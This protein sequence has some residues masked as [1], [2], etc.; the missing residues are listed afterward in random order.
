[1]RRQTLETCLNRPFDLILDCT[2]LGPENMTPHQWLL[3]F[4]SMIP[5][6][7]TA[8]IRDIIVFNINTT[9]KLYARPWFPPNWNGPQNA[10]QEA[11]NS[12]QSQLSIAYCNSIPELEVYIERRNIALSPSSVAIATAPIEIRFNQ[13]TMVWYYRTLIPVSF[14]IG[15]DHLQITALKPQE[16]LPSRMACTNEVFHLAEIDDVRAIS[17]RGD[18]NTFFVTCRGGSVSFLFNSRDRTEIVQALRQAKARV[19]RFRTT[20][21]V[22]RTLLPSDVPGTLLNMAMIN[23]TS[24]D[25]G[26][27]LCAYDLLCALSTS[28]N[29]GASN[30]RK[31]L[32]SAKGKY[33]QKTLVETISLDT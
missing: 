5:P 32:L 22:D 33:S 17:I 28:F 6:E 2:A 25:Y 21:A 23:I 14:R 8:N 31:R 7:V 18:D 30:A 27:R 1:M 15:G 19:S 3:Y 20:K 24:E 4:S 12:M 10:S 11:M 16:I 26:L 13:I 29:F 9:A